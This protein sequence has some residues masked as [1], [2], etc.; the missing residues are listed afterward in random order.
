MWKTSCAR[1]ACRQGELLIKLDDLEINLMLKQRWLE[2]RTRQIRS[3]TNCYG[4]IKKPLKV[5]STTGHHGK[6]KTTGKA[7]LINLVAQKIWKRPVA[8][9]VRKLSNNWTSQITQSISNLKSRSKTPLMMPKRIW[10]NKQ[11]LPTMGQT[12]NGVAP[13]DHKQ[14][15]NRLVYTTS[16]I[17]NGLRYKRR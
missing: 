10:M 17:Q 2:L 12:E 11:S 7:G 5:K 15:T 14:W 13:G 3:E 16:S 8:K 4:L 9:W 6:S 1:T